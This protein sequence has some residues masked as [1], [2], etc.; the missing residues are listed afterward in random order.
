[1]KPD[2]GDHSQKEEHLNTR[3]RPV[4]DRRTNWVR[5]T[6][7]NDDLHFH[8][9]TR[10]RPALQ[11]TDRF[12]YIDLFPE[13]AEERSTG[14]KPAFVP[15]GEGDDQ[16]D[17]VF[18]QGDAPDGVETAEFE[19]ISGFPRQILR[20][21]PLVILLSTVFLFASAEFVPGVTGLSTF[22]PALTG[23]NL[24]LIA[25]SLALW[26]PLIWALSTADMLSIQE[27]VD[28]LV[29]YG[30]VVALG[31]GV[32]LSLYLPTT[33]DHPRMLDP[34]V[35]FLSGYLL[36]LL[37]GGMLLYDAVLKIEHLFVAIG[38]HDVVGNEQR[39]PSFL[40]KLSAA[41]RVEVAGIRSSHV[42]GVLFASQF[43][44]VWIIGNGPQDLNFLPGLA[45]NVFLDVILVIATFQFLVLVQYFHRLMNFT[46]SFADVELTYQP[47]H[48][49]G[50][51]GFRDLGRFALHINVIIIIA[52]LY[53]A[54]RLFVQ[55]GRALPP[56]GIPGFETDIAMVIWTANYMVPV[57]AYALAAGSWLYYSFWQMHRK[58]SHEK[59]SLFSGQGTRDLDVERDAA[60]GD[61][62]TRFP[63]GPDWESYTLAPTWPVDPSQLKS[64]VTGNLVPLV[65]PVFN[66]LF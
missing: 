53:L 18:P 30:L 34:N 62:V 57:V 65:I 35:V 61:P 14:S 49:D 3:P 37:I 54:F 43:A 5:W 26:P 1:M 63:D 40:S 42:F 12:P 51:G 15:N 7:G 27:F 21:T 48:V 56:G 41:L 20:H 10:V 60:A 24:G 19:F 46:D 16:G 66:I 13:E 29:T 52:G 55:G 23:A 9:I 59:E 47:F 32:G 58:M 31:A 64:I 8:R 33:V 45:I 6:D 25:V 39:Y 28:A 22:L 50:H 2:D 17:R 44:I 4:D 11:V 38:K 36:T